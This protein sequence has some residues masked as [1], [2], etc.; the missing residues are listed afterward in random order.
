MEG[1]KICQFLTQ[2]ASH[3][4]ASHSPFHRRDTNP[5]RLGPSGAELC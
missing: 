5:H 1:A 4:E 3:P 2:L